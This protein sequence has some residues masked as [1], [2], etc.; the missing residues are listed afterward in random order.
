MNSIEL[1]LKLGIRQKIDSVD[2]DVIFVWLSIGILGLKR[3]SV[4]GSADVNIHL[5]FEV[6]D[7]MGL[8]CFLGLIFVGFESSSVE[9]D[10]YRFLD[11]L[12]ISRH[13]C[14]IEIFFLI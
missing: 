13:Y 1:A 5:D 14:R 10:K 8:D 9:N 4:K 7:I 3:G 11:V 12:Y 6:L 2:N